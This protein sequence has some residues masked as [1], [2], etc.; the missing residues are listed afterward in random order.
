MSVDTKRASGRRKIRYN[1]LDDFL[2]DAERVAAG[3]TKTVGNW[4]VGQI[5]KHL[6]DTSNFAIDPAPFKPPWL[7]RIILRTFLKRQFLEKPMPAGFNLPKRVEAEL[8]AAPTVTTEEGIESVRR[9]VARLKSTSQRVPHS[10]FGHLS[11]EEWEQFLLR[12]AELHM[13]FAVPE[14]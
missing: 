12:H 8:V 2:A 13:S 6:G 7:V 1:S 10:I 4:S 9:V 14:K 5:L 11:N 3:P